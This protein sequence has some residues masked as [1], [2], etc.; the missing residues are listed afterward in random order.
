M[1]PF[2]YLSLNFYLTYTWVVAILIN[3]IYTA[4]NSDDHFL[5]IDA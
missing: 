5:D 1:T 2:S 3:F 4:I